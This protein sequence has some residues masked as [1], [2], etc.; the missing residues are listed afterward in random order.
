MKKSIIATGLILILHSCVVNEYIDCKYS[1]NNMRSFGMELI[2][3]SLLESFACLYAHQEASYSKEGLT[4]TMLQPNLW[5]VKKTTGSSVFEYTIKKNADE[6][7]SDWV[8][9]DFYLQYDEE[10]AYT[11]II[12]ATTELQIAWQ[13][14]SR[15]YYYVL[16]GSFQMNTYKDGEQIE[17]ITIRCEKED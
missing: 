9:S 12:Q 7:L 2:D 16:T 17:T 8:C 3:N 11:A 4:I 15:I 13:W 1:K 10:N 14:Q 6:E 5:K